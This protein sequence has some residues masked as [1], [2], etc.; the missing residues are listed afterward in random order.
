M[1]PFID[2]LTLTIFQLDTASF[3]IIGLLDVMLFA[4]DPSLSLHRHFS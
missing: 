2:Q 4:Q 1:S 3:W